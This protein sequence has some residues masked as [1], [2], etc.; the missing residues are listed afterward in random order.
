MS[1]VSDYIF[2]SLNFRMMKDFTS[3][4]IDR[5]TVFGKY[6]HFDI[7]NPNKLF[8]PLFLVQ[9]TTDLIKRGGYNNINVLLPEIYSSTKCKTTRKLLSTFASLS[10]NWLNKCIVKGVKYFGTK[11]AIFDKNMNP[12][13]MLMCDWN[14]DNEHININKIMFLVTKDVFTMPDNIIKKAIIKE[15]FPFC[16]NFAIKQYH[17]LNNFA[18]SVNDLIRFKKEND[19]ISIVIDDLTG[20]IYKPVTPKPSLFEENKVKEFISNNVDMILDDYKGILP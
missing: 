16:C 8:T 2:Q 7:S 11:G 12:I 19:N 13:L 6:L 5:Y 10:P 9:K 4:D 3:C 15:I 18:L 1:A 17:V 20:F 14:Y